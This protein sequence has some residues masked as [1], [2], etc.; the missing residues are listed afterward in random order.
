M[1]GRL[2]SDIDN[3]QA[4][5]IFEILQQ[6]TALFRKYGSSDIDEMLNVL[7]VCNVKKGEWIC[8]KDEPIDMLVIVLYGALRVGK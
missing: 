5:R 1:A 2:I 7:K 6:E 8:R 3:N 4:K